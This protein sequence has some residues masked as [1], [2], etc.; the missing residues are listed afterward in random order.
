MI[1]QNSKPLIV[2]AAAQADSPSTSRRQ[3]R[4]MQV[5]ARVGAAIRRDFER[6]EEIN[7][8]LEAFKQDAHRKCLRY[9]LMRN[10]Y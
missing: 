10:F 6:G 5:L 1:A 3:F 7:R 4:P 9:G 8:Q 2:A